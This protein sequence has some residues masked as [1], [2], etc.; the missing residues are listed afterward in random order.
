VAYD[1]KLVFILVEASQATFICTFT[2]FK[3]SQEFTMEQNQE[4]RQVSSNSF[5]SNRKKE[6]L[7]TPI[8]GVLSFSDGFEIE[9]VASKPGVTILLPGNCNKT[10]FSSLAE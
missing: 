8:I 5:R 3:T 6:E 10:I 7:F 2:D 9:P 4:R 1:Q